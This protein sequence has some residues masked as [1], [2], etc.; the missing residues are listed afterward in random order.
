VGRPSQQQ[1]EPLSSASRDIE[2]YDQGTVLPPHRGQGPSAEDVAIRS[3][4]VAYDRLKQEPIPDR[5]LALALQL[6]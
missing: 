4:L 6:R 3:M 5:L 2:G 1:A